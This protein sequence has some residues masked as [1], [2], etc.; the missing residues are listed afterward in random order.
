MRA[1][2]LKPRLRPV[3]RGYLTAM[4]V[5]VID[6][7]EFDE[8]DSATAPPVIVINRTIARRYFGTRSPVG[9]FVDWHAGRGPASQMQVVGVVDDVRNVSPDREA[10]PEIFLDY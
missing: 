7:R 4:G 5:R 2:P 3:S 8:A 1:D 10:F 9:Q 6:G